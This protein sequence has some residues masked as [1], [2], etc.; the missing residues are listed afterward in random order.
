M[1]VINVAGQ[2]GELKNLMSNE[3]GLVNIPPEA[4]P[5]DFGVQPQTW[6]AGDFRKT[7]NWAQLLLQLRDVP[8]PD[9]TTDLGKSLIFRPNVSSD[10]PESK[11]IFTV[12][13]DIPENAKH[14]DTADEADKLTTPRNFSISGI[15]DSDPVPFDGTANVNLVIPQLKYPLGITFQGMIQEVSLS[16]DASMSQY[17]NIAITL[18]NPKDGKVYGI[19]NNNYVDITSSLV[20]PNVVVDGSNPLPPVNDIPTNSF[21]EYRI[22]T[23]LTLNLTTANTATLFHIYAQAEAIEFTGDVIAQASGGLIV[24]HGGLATVKKLSTG[25]YLIFGD[26]ATS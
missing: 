21:I 13:W 5:P 6:A 26:T 15:A 23:P 10:Y 2:P 1:P 24:P 7:D 20:P 17:F 11:S 18:D 3:Y 4:I 8:F 25:E 9:P 22:A 14:A 12:E 19:Q 16:Y